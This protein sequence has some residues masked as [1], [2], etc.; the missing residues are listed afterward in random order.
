VA[1]KSKG[2]IKN[3]PLDEANGEGMEFEGEY[4]VPTEGVSVKGCGVAVDVSLSLGGADIVVV[5]T[6]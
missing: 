1:G 6:C 4:E 2:W 3:V 5:G